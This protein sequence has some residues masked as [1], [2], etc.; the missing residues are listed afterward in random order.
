MFATTLLIAVVVAGFVAA[1][2]LGSQAYFRGEMTKPIHERNWNSKSFDQLAET[3]TGEKIEGM[4]REPG[5][6]VSDAYAS[7]AIAE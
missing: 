7:S 1:I 3:I 5:F 4:T 6:I 2:T